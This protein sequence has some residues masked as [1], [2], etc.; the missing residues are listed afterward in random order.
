MIGIRHVLA[1]GISAYGL[2]A[3]A[4]ASAGLVLSELIVDLQPGKHVRDDI[5]VWND[6]PERA[7]IAVDPR[8]I[9]DPGMTSQ[10]ARR[11]P[12]P[13]KLGILVSPARMI[14]EA[15][16]RK[17]VRVATLSADTGREHVYRVTIKPVVGAIEASDTGLKL[18]VGYDVLVLVRPSQPLAEVAG[19]RSGRKL[20]F[21][22]T[23]NVSVEL[24][25]G[26]QCGN[27]GEQCADLPGKRLYP[28][29]SWTVDLG[30]DAPASYTLKS[31]GRSDR[32]TY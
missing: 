8:E 13:E 25:G 5:E 6:S 19:L 10:S 22:N 31:P 26:R 7:F 2:A 27:A 18:L 23:G 21:R 9:V 30:S 29:A 24:V 28:G 3:A 15:G 4:P 1:L 32:R 11:D 12:D 20:T 17:L 16:Q 14:L